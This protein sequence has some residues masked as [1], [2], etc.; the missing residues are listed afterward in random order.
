MLP[1]KA[2]WRAGENKDGFVGEVDEVEARKGLGE[3]VD[4]CRLN[5]DCRPA[6]VGADCGLCQ[7]CDHRSFEPSLAMPAV[8]QFNLSILDSSFNHAHNIH[9][10][11][12][13]S[14]MLINTA[15]AVATRQK[16]CLQLQW[17]ATID[18]DALTMTNQTIKPRMLSPQSIFRA[19]RALEMCRSSSNL[20][21]LR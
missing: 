20:Q 17:S 21:G 18:F 11:L 5:G 10:K 3:F 4:G 15:P 16:S 19:F 2:F 1:E 8:C 12:M 7:Y 9:A 13:P 14:A 6:E